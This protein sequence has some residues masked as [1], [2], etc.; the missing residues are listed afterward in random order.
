[1]DRRAWA[2][3][4][5]LACGFSWTLTWLAQV[6]AGPD[7]LPAVC[8]A[9]AWLGAVLFL[10]PAAVAAARPLG[11]I[12]AAACLG[13]ALA[14]VLLLLFTGALPLPSA[15]LVA[16]MLYFCGVVLGLAPPRHRAAAGS[17]LVFGVCLAAASPVW[18]GPAID[19][20]EPD[21]G[22]VDAL[23]AVNPFTHLAVTT[24][25]DFLRSDWLYRHS[26]LGGLRFDYPSPAAVLLFYLAACALGSL[27]LRRRSAPERRQARDFTRSSTQAHPE[28]LR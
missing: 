8:A 17:W 18:L 13:A 22:A 23:I 19:R 7:L 25:I 10:L 26:P 11:A 4:A 14:A 12:A 20:I 24:G 15:V 3:G 5:L 21:K 9:A 28:I 16:L 6:R 2:F 1:M 27:A